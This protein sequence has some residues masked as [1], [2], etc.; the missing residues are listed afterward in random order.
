MQSEQK[1]LKKKNMCKVHFGI[2]LGK[3]T[4]NAA[5]YCESQGTSAPRSE[6]MLLINY[7]VM[8]D[9]RSGWQNESGSM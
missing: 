7:V 6:S 1:I 4:K 3:Q 9:K 2:L 8:M 5:E